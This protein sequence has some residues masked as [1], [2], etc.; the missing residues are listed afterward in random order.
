MKLI[1]TINED[2]KKAIKEKNEIKIS[3]LRQIKNQITNTE[4]KKGR[5]LSDE[6]IGEAIFSL[7]KS[8]NESIESFKSGNRPDLV[9]KE[10][11]EL[12]VLKTYL[13]EQ[14]SEEDLKKIISE[15]IAETGATSVKDIG[16]VMGKLM[17]KVKGRADGAKVKLYVEEFFNSQK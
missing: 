3:V 11:K 13:P 15:T 17:P 10:E 6:E 14:L 9:E 5:T 12:S 2:L 1:D 7:V 4:I 16:K 8:H